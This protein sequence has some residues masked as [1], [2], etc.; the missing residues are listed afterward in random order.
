MFELA[1]RNVVITGASSGIGWSAALAYSAAGA[2]VALLARRAEKLRELGDLVRARG[3]VSFEAACDVSDRGQALEAVR[4]ARAALGPIDVLVNNAGV[5]EYLRFAEQD[6]A[7]VEE[8]VRVN[9]LGAAAMTY[10]VL[11]EMLERRTGHILNVASLAGL[12]GVPFMAAY[13]ASKF[14]LVGFTESLR[15]ELYGTGVTLTAFCP[16]TVKTPMAEKA[17]TDPAIARKLRIKTPEA[18]A[19]RMV[20][21]TRRRLPEVVYGEVPGAVLKLAKFAPG[22]ADWATHKVYSRLQSLFPSKKKAAA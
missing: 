14:A 15:V 22:F 12:R 17:L 6:F 9:F 4:K 5:N 11:P 1:G 7:A 3:G 20:D 13:C 19:E 16:G 2:R 18:V 10:A 8:I 21:A